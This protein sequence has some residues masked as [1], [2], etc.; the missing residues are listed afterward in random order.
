[1]AQKQNVK[2]LKNEI[3]TRQINF[4]IPKKKLPIFGL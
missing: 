2:K 1:M 3:F 4:K